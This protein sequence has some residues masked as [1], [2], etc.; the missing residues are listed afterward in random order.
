ML[1]R[2][3][4]LNGETK[5]IR[6]QGDEWGKQGYGRKRLKVVNINNT[7]KGAYELLSMIIA[8]TENKIS[9]YIYLK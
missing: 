3:K 4:S 8:L 9:N 2:S 7:A 6:L 5:M 1:A